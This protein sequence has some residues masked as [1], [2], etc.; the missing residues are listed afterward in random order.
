LP[1][2]GIVY[3][4]TTGDCERVASWLRRNGIDAAEYHAQLPPEQ[5]REDLERY[6]EE[7]RSESDVASAFAVERSQAQAW[8]ARAV[9][10]GKAQ[11]LSRPV[12]YRTIPQAHDQ[13]GLFDPVDRS[14]ESDQSL[15]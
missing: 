6:L 1:G 10:E 4:L 3:C 14:R 11:K 15:M 8:L 12:R 2:S 9:R 13:K 7:P 5:N